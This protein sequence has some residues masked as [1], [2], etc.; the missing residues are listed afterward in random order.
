MEI[1]PPGTVAVAAGNS[2]KKTVI[3]ILLGASCAYAQTTNLTF[4]WH[5]QTMGVDFKET[6]LTDSVKNAIRDDIG[7]A[8]SLISFTNISYE[9]HSPTHPDYGKR[10]GVAAIAES[11]PYNYCDGII[12]DY[13]AVGNTTT[14]VLCNSACSNYVA[15]IALTNQYALQIAAFSNF[16]HHVKTGF[17]VTGLTLAE[18]KSFFWGSP[19]LEVWEESEGDGFEQRLTQALSFRPNPLPPNVFPPNPAILAFVVYMDE[20]IGIPQPTL[21]CEVRRWDPVNENTQWN[22]IWID[23][24]WRYC[25]LGPR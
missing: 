8:M 22:F 24:K 2:M 18:K 14:F 20:D 3:F 6:N 17:D 7:Y 25:L 21:F 11:T 15:T 10:T 4:Q 9:A 16:F 23:G 19:F 5:G 13:K 1:L 12:N